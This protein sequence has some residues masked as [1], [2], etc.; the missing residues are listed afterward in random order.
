[1]ESFYWLIEGALAGCGRPGG[2][3]GRERGGYRR[4]GAGSPEERER[5]RRALDADLSWLKEHGIGAVLS[6]TETPL[7]DGA[8]ERHGL[9][10]LHLPVDDLTAPTPEQLD[11]ALAFIDAQRAH[12]RRVA[13]HCLMGQG[14]TGTVL[15]AYLVRGGATTEAALREVRSVCPGA[16]GSPEQER[17]LRA[18]EGRRD[19][20]V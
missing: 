20:I 6:L 1:M 4:D 5:A 10:G 17:A 7:A 3:D 14:R 19:W 2:L 11:R 9:D 12:G 16:V 18:F 13:V 15:A 8:I